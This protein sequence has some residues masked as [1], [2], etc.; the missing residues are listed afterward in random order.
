MRTI[1]SRV[2]NLDELHLEHRRN[3]DRFERDAARIGPLVGAKDLGYS[4]VVVPPGK[5]ACP[6]HSHRAEEEMFFVVRGEGTLRYGGQT[7]KIRAGDVI[8]CPVGGPETA[9]QIVNDS[10]APLAYLAV[11]TVMPAEVCEYPDSG[12][13]GAFGADFR[14]MTRAGD[15]VDYWAGE[16]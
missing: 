2:V 11:S 12:K 10:A 16:A 9:H 4:Y 13:V 15:Q 6:F 5:R 3:G 14:H 1:D 7:R 8:C